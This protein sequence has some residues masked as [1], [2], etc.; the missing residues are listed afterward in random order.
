MDTFIARLHGLVWGDW[1]VLF[2]IGTGLFFTV[3][4]R[5]IQFRWMRYLLRFHRSENG[6]SSQLRTV[7][8]SL[9]AAMGTGN[10]TGVA[11][12]LAAGGAGAVFWMWVSAFFGMAVVYAENVLS[13]RFSKGRYKGPMAYLALGA[14]SP[15]A[16]ALFAV[17]CCLAA[18]GMGGMVQV[19]SFT[20]ALYTCTD[21]NRYVTAVIVLAIVYA[22][23]SGGAL[24]IGRTAQ[25]LVP[26]AT[27]LYMGVSIAVLVKFGDRL[28]AV[29]RSIIEE[30]LGFRQAAGGIAGY[31]ISRA[32][33]VGVRRGVFSNEAGLGSS[34]L[35]HSSAEKQEPR[36]QGMWAMAEVFFDTMVCCTLTAA[37]ILCASDDFTIA[38]AFSHIL[39]NC[40]EAAVT[41][42]LGAYAFC[43]MIGWYFCGETALHCLF[44]KADRKAA[45]LVY[46][47]VSALGAVITAENVWLISD[48]FNG[49]MAVPNLIGLI[50]LSGYV[51][52]E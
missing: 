39:G 15:A 22:V 31:G 7:C 27:V 16:A 19:S 46:A 1:L 9:G 34:P 29:F 23:I 30:A 42:E 11:A 14:E 45:A 44:P 21:A 12:A 33:S 38:S 40:S 37:V 2:I 8:M 3:R 36:L 24:R 48:I 13:C 51:K 6:G 52:E 41:A 50:V 20:E 32:V 28:P 47:V 10:I 25:F 26:A 35:L 18:L 17:F 43:T 49:L 5:G 4:L